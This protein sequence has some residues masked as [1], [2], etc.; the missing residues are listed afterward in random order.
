M[1]NKL[2]W[3]GPVNKDGSPSPCESFSPF[4]K[5]EAARASQPAGEAINERIKTYKNKLQNEN[6]PED[7]AYALRFAIEALEGVKPAMSQPAGQVVRGI[8]TGIYY[9]LERDNFYDARTFLGQGWKFHGDWSDLAKQFPQTPKAALIRISTI[10]RLTEQV[11]V[12]RE[13]VTNERDN[14]FYAMTRGAECDVGLIKERL[15]CALAACD[16]IAKEK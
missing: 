1:S 13:T 4:V 3:N 7:E 12:L 2:P 15:T 9:N 6:P 8:P 11:R 10:T 5:A 14:I 16:A